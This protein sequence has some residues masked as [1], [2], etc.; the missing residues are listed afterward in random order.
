MHV[1]EV[2]VLL[3]VSIHAYQHPFIGIHSLLCIQL[4]LCPLTLTLH[5]DLL[6]PALL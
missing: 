4:P 5:L 2:S 1:S 6:C 3:I